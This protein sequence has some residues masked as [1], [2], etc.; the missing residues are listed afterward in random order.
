M[1]KFSPDHYQHQGI[2]TWDYIAA[3]ELDYFLGNVCKYISRAG[4]K[5]GEEQL[6]DLRKAQAYLHKK[7]QLIENAST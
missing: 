6:D 7:I 1:N 5:P 3:A 2:Q 4:L